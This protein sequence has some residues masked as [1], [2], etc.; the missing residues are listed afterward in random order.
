MKFCDIWDEIVTQ[1]DA[2]SRRTRRDN[3]L[4][5]DYVLNETTGNN[6]M[7]KDEMRRLFYSTLDRVISEI[8]VRFSPQNTKLHAAV[9]ALQPENSKFWDVKI[10]QSLLD[11]VDCT[12]VEAEFDVAKSYVAKFNH[13]EKTKSTTTKLFFEHCEEL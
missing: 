6:E 4:L 8:D 9:L 3:R 1:I 13:D 12:S 2:H 10:V 11:L 5:L 7:N